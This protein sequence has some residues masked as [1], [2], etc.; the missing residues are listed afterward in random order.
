MAQ[1]E[2]LKIIVKAEVNKAIADLKKLQGQTG[3]NHDGAG[4]NHRRSQCVVSA[5]Q[6][7]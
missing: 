6:F 7:I 2:E 4:R 5:T 3:K 1:S